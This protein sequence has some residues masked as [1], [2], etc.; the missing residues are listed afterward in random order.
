MKNHLTLTFFFLLFG[1]Q[2]FTQEENLNNQQID[3]YKGIWFELGQPYEF[4]DKYS[5][6]LGTYTAKHRPLAI[7]AEEVDKTFFVFGGTVAENKRQLLCMIG[8]YDHASG[9]VPKPTVVYDKQGV[10]DPHDN[11]SLLIDH[12]GYLWVYVS[13]RS[14]KRMGYK[15][16]S[17][18]PYDIHEFEQITDEEMTYPQPWIYDNGKVIHLFTKYTGVRE[19]YFET[20]S[21]GYTWS[22]DKK[23]AGIREKGHDRGGH[24]QVSA[25]YGDVVGTF[26]NRHPKGDVDRRTDLYYLQISD[27]GDAWNTVDNKP[28]KIPLVEVDIPARAVDYYRLKLNVY[29]KDMCFDKSGYPVCLYVTSRGHEPGPVNNPREFRITRW[30]G[31]NWKTDIVCETDHNYDMGS[32]D[33][34]GDEWTVIVPSIDG[35][36]HYGTGG[37]IGMWKSFDNGENWKLV[38]Q[39]TVNSE[40]NHAYVRRSESAKD[41][42]AFFWADGNPEKLS[43]SKLYFSSSEGKVWQLPYEMKNDMEKPIL[44]EQH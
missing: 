33:I 10:D 4:G 43:I 7:Y 28:V 36:Q 41:P 11:P 32:I 6:G 22:D 8:Y 15:Y 14:T 5:G 21:D 29:L 37:E 19:L 31:S 24:Y 42:F 38:K 9:M 27:T 23:L 30:D 12:D 16:K 26:L 1:V 20:S 13:G 3:G 2:G 40:R 17:K 39:L 25:R 18:K 35:P 34:N 44:M